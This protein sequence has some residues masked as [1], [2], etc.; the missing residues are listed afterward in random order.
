MI[1]GGFMSKPSLFNAFRK[2][3]KCFVVLTSAFTVIVSLAS[4]V[5]GLTLTLP[6]SLPIV[7]GFGFLGA[8]Y[9][10]IQSWY[11]DKKEIQQ[12]EVDQHQAKEIR[13]DSQKQLDVL[14]K[15][16]QKVNLLFKEKSVSQHLISEAKE[17]RKRAYSSS[18]SGFFSTTTAANDK[19]F[20]S[21]QE[22]Q[23]TPASCLEKA[24]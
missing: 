21:S 11:K 19:D 14:N 8:I 18:E 15:L 16:D 17:K 2:A 24:K 9:Y 10:G 1:R 22:P 5:A 7:V 13:S 23:A 12:R 6:I 20:D 3:A 4:V